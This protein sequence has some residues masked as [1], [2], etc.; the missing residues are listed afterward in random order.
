MAHVVVPVTD[1]TINTRSGDLVG[2]G[3]AIAN[4]DTFEVNV[5]NRTDQLMLLIEETAAAAATSTFTAGAEPPNLQGI[6]GN[7]AIVLAA[8]DLRTFVLEGG[9]FIQTS[10]KITGS[11][12]GAVRMTAFRIPKTW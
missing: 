11:Q 1:L 9:R 3:T 10:G 12:A 6:H 4:T 5:E 2:S 7:L 8:S